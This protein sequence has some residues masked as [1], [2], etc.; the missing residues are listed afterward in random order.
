[1]K[2]K[3]PKTGEEIEALRLALAMSGVCVNSQAACV[4]NEVFK[5]I[6]KKGGKFAI[7]DACRINYDVRKRYE[8]LEVKAVPNE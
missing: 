7:D 2:D 4:I 3:L 1:M 6:Q 8:K 5:E